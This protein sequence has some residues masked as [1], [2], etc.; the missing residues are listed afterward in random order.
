MITII[1]TIIVFSTNAIT[2]ASDGTCTANISTA[3]ITSINGGS[4]GTKNLII[5]GGLNVYQRGSTRA[6]TTQGNG[7]ATADRWKNQWNNPS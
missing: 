2:L 6:S 5:N 3:N 1:T 4:I 7:Y